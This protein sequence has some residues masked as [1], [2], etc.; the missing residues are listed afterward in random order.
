MTKHY[1]KFLLLFVVVLS[2]FILA[3]CGDNTKLVRVYVQ[4]NESAYELTEDRW[5]STNN[6]IT[7]FNYGKDFEV[8]EVYSNHQVKIAEKA[9]INS[10]TM[11]QAT[12]VVTLEIDTSQQG[13]ANLYFSVFIP[14]SGRTI[15]A[16]GTVLF[17]NVRY[18]S[19]Y[20]QRI[21]ETKHSLTQ[22][23][24]NYAN[25]DNIKADAFIVSG[26]NEQRHTFSNGVDEDG[27]SNGLTFTN[28]GE[29]V[30]NKN[31]TNYIDISI[32]GIVKTEELRVDIYK[33]GDNQLPINTHNK[34]PFGTWSWVWD[35]PLIIPIGWLMSILSFG[36]IFGI[37]IILSTFAIRTL[38]W[39]VYSKTAN[40]SSNMQLAQ[41]ELN[42]MRVKYAGRKDPQ[43]QQKMM[44]EQ[45]KIMKKYNVSM[46]GCF[47]PLLQMPLFMAM[48]Q[49]VNRITVSG[50]LFNESL[51][52]LSFLGI[53]LTQGNNWQTYILAGI[54]GVTMFLFQKVTTIKPKHIKNT[55][56]HAPKTEKQASTEK[57]MKIV[58]YVM[59]AFMVFASMQ[60]AALALYWIAGNIH[61]IIQTIINRKL[62]ERKHEKQQKDLI[63]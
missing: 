50:G 27:N 56:T 10:Y 45:K 25:L 30:T 21:D 5:D 1:K 52:N 3:A 49:V 33:P 59:I 53:N 12:G 58:N 61:S 32:Q 11:D 46:L 14:I 62:T 60:L 16:D 36:G 4:A 43:S 42:R 41:P 22:I 7:G 35:Y 63:I 13:D 44:A 17:A 40:M 51:T 37:G 38:M 23:V 48:Y 57:T 55:A 19:N 54:V 29:F 47:M 39:P 9:T 26:G 31:A 20:D 15:P 28:R 18:F 6:V 24:A 8:Y 34:I 2:T